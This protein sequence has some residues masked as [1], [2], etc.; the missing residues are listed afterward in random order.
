MYIHRKKN[1]TENNIP[2]NDLMSIMMD[3]WNV[4]EMIHGMWFKELNVFFHGIYW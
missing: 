2:F 3:S 4:I 1:L